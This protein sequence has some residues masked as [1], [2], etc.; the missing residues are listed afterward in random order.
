MKNNILERIK[1]IMKKKIV[2]RKIFEF[3]KEFLKYISIV[4][5]L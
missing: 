3:F 2:V 5:Y 4:I 1:V